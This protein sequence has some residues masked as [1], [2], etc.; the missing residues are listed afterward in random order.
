MSNPHALHGDMVTA[1]ALAKLAIA[2]GGLLDEYSAEVY[3]DR[4]DRFDPALVA[5]A[6]AELSDT[7]RA[8]FETTL[9]EVGRIIERVE[10][11]AR[12]DADE[13][14]RLRLLPSR[15]VRDADEPTFHCLACFDE[16]AAWRSFW[17]PGEPRELAKPERASRFSS[18]DCG[19]PKKH[20]GHFYVARCECSDT[21]PVIR[22]H[23][24]RQ[25]QFR[26]Q[27]TTR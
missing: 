12:K 13:A 1:E 22:G 19:R 14:A 23:R 20:I 6:C 17:C 16:P 3:L 21:N 11:L 25:A 15:V 10:A 2:R 7:P 8:E 26:Q 9:P 24:D 18:V 5:R 4:L 27:K